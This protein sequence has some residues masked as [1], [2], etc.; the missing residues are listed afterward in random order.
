VVWSIAGD[1]GFQMTMAELA[2]IVENKVPVKFAILNNNNLGLVRQ[3]QDLFNEGSRVAS[4]YT[5]NP[6]F[7]K[8]AGAYGIW[9][10]RV[11]ERAQVRDAIEAAM[12][13]DGPALIDFRVDPEENIYPHLPAGESVIEMIEEHPMAARESA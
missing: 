2:T 1:G 7:V 9:S 12:A 10:A 3:L 8:L 4:G 5:G 13:H 6:D 11:T